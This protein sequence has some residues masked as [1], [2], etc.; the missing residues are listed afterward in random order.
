P[1]SRRIGKRTSPESRVPSPGIHSPPHSLCYPPPK[2]D[3]RESVMARG[4]HHRIHAQDRLQ[5][6]RY[7]VAQEAARLIS[8]HAIHDYRRAKLKAAER[9][10]IEADQAL[11]RNREIE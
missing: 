9:L 7:R 1:F 6:N 11:P 3:N 10:G 4:E 8:E 2:H 5:R